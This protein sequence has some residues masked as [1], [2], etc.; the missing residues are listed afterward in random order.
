MGNKKDEE[1]KDAIESKFG[2]RRR[3]SEEKDVS[4]ERRMRRAGR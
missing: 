3:M 1:S 4:V 2:E